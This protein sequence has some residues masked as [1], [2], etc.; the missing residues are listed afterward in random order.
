M[1]VYYLD[2]LVS[3]LK[4]TKRPWLPFMKGENVLTGL[5]IVR[6]GGQDTQ[7]P[8]DTDEVYYVAEGKGK[9][10]VGEKTVLVQA[11]S[12]LFV[13]AEVEHRFF[14]IEEDLVLLVFFDQ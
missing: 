6:A 2:S 5:Y 3:K 9:F 8:H 7:Q 4:P 12:I 10:V 11:G 14:D 13:K 1:A